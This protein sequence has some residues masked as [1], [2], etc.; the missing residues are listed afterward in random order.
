MVALATQATAAPHAGVHITDN[1]YATR[2]ITPQE[3]WAVGAFGVI[4]HTLDG[5]ETWR[6]QVS[7]TVEPLFS[8]DFA[9]PEHG[10][11]CGRSGVILHT[12]DGGQHWRLQPSGSPRHLFKVAALDRQRAWVVGDWGVILAT[13]D[14]GATWED[15]SLARDVILNGQSWPNSERGWIVGEAG[16][17]LATDNGGRTW[18]DQVS[19]VQKTL[20]G[21]AFRN[22]QEGWAVGID[23]LIL[24]TTDAGQTWQ[25]QHGNSQVGALA[26]VG[27]VQ[28]LSNPSL[29]DVAV[30]GRYG[31]AVGDA[32]AVFASQ[33]GGHTWHRVKTS[34]KHRLGWIRSVSLVSGTHGLYVGAGGLAV[35]IAHGR[36]A[37]REHK[38]NAAEAAH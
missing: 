14:G 33:D 24:H 18:T 25:V 4:F 1:L 19:G 9:D 29:Y 36:I 20:F 21:V 13:H 17:I 5:A 38:A 34:G 35:R 12:D 16:T 26:Q 30:V 27:F 22:P 8:V 23:G 10:W 3:G 15:H 6:P 32:G 7:H 37:S 28:A 11:I 31:Y 2:F